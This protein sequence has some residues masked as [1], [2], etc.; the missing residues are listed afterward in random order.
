MPAKHAV[1]GA[2]ITLDRRAP[3]GANLPPVTAARV[4]IAIGA[5]LV[6]VSAVI[7]ILLGFAGPSFFPWIPAFLGIPLILKGVL[8]L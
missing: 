3:V 5:C 8:E 6:L 1:L 7:A 4:K 2:K